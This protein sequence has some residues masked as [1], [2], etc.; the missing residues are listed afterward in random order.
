MR[1]SEPIPGHA[2]TIGRL[3]AASGCKVQTIRWYEEIGLLP[4]APRSAGNQR[5]YGQAALDRLLF[6]RH[7]RGLG[8]PLDAV[9]DL[10]RLADAPDQPCA[11]ADVIARRQL[12]EVEQRL[13]R[14]Q[15]LKTELE[16][17]IRQC[18]G[19]RIA[20]CRVIESLS[21]HSACAG[22]TH[23]APDDATP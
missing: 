19:G 18:A 21:D 3:A 6:I 16:R 5:L 12:T 7:A 9:R 8:F 14:L 11:D 22:A 20:D 2:F 17:M 1:K 23:L 15:S 4:I 13:Q 10:L